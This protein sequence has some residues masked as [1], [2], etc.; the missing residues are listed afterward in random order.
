VL[1]PPDEAGVGGRPLLN[2][3]YAVNYA[4]GGANLQGYHLTNL[5]IHILAGLALFGLV[6]RTL[7]RP[8]LAARFG[9]TATW[10]SFFIAAIWTWNPLQTESVTYISQRAESLMGLFYL[11]TLYSF[12]RGADSPGN[13]ARFLWYTFSA[14]SCLAGAATKEVIVTVPVIAL[15]YDRTFISG[16]FSAAWRRNWPLYAALASSWVLLGHRVAGLCS[17]G[18][19]YGVGFGSGLGWWDYAMTESRVVVKY[20]L[21]AFWP[22]PL[23][24]DYGRNLPG[25]FLAVWPYTVVLALMV[26]GAAF[27]LRKSPSV[28]FAACW[29]LL[30]LAPT[31]SI[32]PL[33]GQPMAESRMYLPL[34]GVVA[35]TVLGGF[36][37]AGRA[38]MA[39]FG[40]VAACL[41][42]GTFQRNKDY[43]SELRIWSDTVA[44]VPQNARARGNLGRVLARIPGRLNDAAAEHRVAVDLEPS[45]P[46]LRV[47]LGNIMYRMPGHLDEAIGQY[48][49]ALRL[50]PDDAQVHFDLGCALG[51]V[52]GRLDESIAQFEQALDLQPDYAPAHCNLGNC[53]LKIPGRSDDAIAHFGA[54]LRLNPDFAEAHLGLATALLQ[55]PGREEEA[56]IHLRE[57]LRLDPGNREA[58][59]MLGDFPASAP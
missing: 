41:A 49:E 21:L 28:G 16:S 44:K 42:V 36:A 25:Q 50:K 17:G 33:A 31:S 52:P 2:F 51:S 5:V 39:A 11:L 57:V 46:E 59:G 23:V 26:A 27:A 12:V 19:V 58:T 6:R 15:L 3:S 45:V 38:S 1:K 48:E 22:S 34:A 24:F 4:A 14:L 55:R 54:A 53:L 13:R 29:F 37:L 10:L 47:N 7:L 20:L 43:A 40:V 9:P 35:L 32:I 30:I 8:I 56:R 18:L